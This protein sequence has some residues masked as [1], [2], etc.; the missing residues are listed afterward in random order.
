MGN[1]PMSKWGFEVD[2][3]HGEKSFESNI[4]M[5]MKNFLSLRIIFE[6][7]FFCD[8]NFRD[9]WT[10]FGTSNTTTACTCFINKWISRSTFAPL[11]MYQTP[12]LSVKFE[13]VNGM[14]W[15][16]N[17]NRHVFSMQG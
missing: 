16:K 3:Q 1:L 10:I 15:T 13:M 2:I 4:E 6:A 11:F 9:F 5:C 14:F 8:S 17:L 7:D 12:L